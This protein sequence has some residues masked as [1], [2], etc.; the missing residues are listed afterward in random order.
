MEKVYVFSFMTITALLACTSITSIATP[1]PV[2]PVPEILIRTDVL[3]KFNDCKSKVGIEA[4]GNKSSFSC[5]NSAD[6]SYTISISHFE[7]EAA[8]YTQFESSRG[9]IPVSCFHGYNLYETSLNNPNN[10]YIVKE[11]LSWLAG[12]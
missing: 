5:S 10:P 4:D 12:Q 6:T 2:R 8:A 3:Q 7:S 9:D 11:N 1:T